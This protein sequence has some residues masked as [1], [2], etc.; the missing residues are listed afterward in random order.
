VHLIGSGVPL[1]LPGKWM[2]HATLE[3]T[4]LYASVLGAEERG[5]AVWMWP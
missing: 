4:A 5:I 3:V 2:G 1:N